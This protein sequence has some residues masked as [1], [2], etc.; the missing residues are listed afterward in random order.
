MLEAGVPYLMATFAMLF[1]GMSALTWIHTVNHLDP[2]KNSRLGGP[3]S[4]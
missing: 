1:S 4:H 3:L 2:P